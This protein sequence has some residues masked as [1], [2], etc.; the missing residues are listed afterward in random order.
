[1]LHTALAPEGPVVRWPR[2][3]ARGVELPAVPQV[4]EEG[5]SRTTRE[6]SDVAILAFG[7]MVQ[8]AEGAADILAK[9]GVSV[10]VVDMRW[11][12]PFDEEAVRK[13]RARMQA[14]VHG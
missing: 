2:G 1:M 13:C 7:R 3:E 6:G 4:L 9:E 10:R 12:K 5:I 8:E 11:I 14:R